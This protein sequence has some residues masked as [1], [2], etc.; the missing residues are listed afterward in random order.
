MGLFVNGT[1]AADVAQPLPEDSYSSSDKDTWIPELKFG[2]KH[3]YV[4]LYGQIN[5]GLLVYDDGRSSLGYFPVD[6]DSSS[7]RAGIKFFSQFDESWSF[8]GNVEGEWEPYSTGYVNQLTRGEVDWDAALLRKAEV[9]LNN[10][11][12]GRLWLGQGSMAS[13]GTAEADLSGTSLTGYSSVADIAG[14][15]FYRLKDGMLSGIQVA[16]AF[17]NLDGVGRKLRARYDTPDVHGLVLGISVGQQVVPERTDVTVWDI[18]AK[19]NNTH[20]DYQIS[21]GLAYS[22]PGG[23]SDGIIDGSV[24]TLHV[25]SGLSL[26]FASAIEFRSDRDLRYFY[27]KLGYQTS[28][29]EAGRTALS[30]DAYHGD[31]INTAGSKSDSIG[32][33]AVQSFDYWK[34][35]LYFGVRS[36]RYDDN[37]GD[38]KNGLAAITG[39]RLKF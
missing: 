17:K 4:L 5:K 23:S 36:Y 22:R 28:Y 12:F 7:T 27:G 35:D 24:S 2:D 34:T 3:G 13:D 15:Q 6:N 9:Y 10:E 32:V 16:G 21:S 30:I 20:G 33:Q 14:S 18:A 1:V 8:G 29:F 39:V 11:A 31:H 37:A 25:P 26:T 38:Y 19:Y